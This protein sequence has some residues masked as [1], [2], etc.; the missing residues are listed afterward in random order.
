[1]KKDSSFSLNRFWLNFK[2]TAGINYTSF[3]TIFIL[4]VVIVMLLNVILGSVSS[5]SS[6]YHSKHT[7]LANLYFI[8]LYIIGIKFASS[9]FSEMKN[10]DEKITYLMLPA[11]VFEKY[12]CRLFMTTV[13]FFI[14]Y[15][16]AY[17]L[18]CFIGSIINYYLF[19]YPVYYLN[20]YIIGF[21]KIIAFFIVCHSIFFL[22]GIWFN[23]FA[24]IKTIA[25]VCLILVLAI[26]VILGLALML[27]FNE[28]IGP[29]NIDFY[30]MSKSILFIKNWFICLLYIF[31]PVMCWITGYY[32]LKESSIK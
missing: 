6:V 26:I 14:K 25:F 30:H 4:T 16:V 13:I 7:V 29:N 19:G 15:T 2:Y 11:S 18:G 23:K 31:L 1:M 27:K 9:A 8:F 28:L 10:K 5:I 21:W 17:L 12:F 32:K 24:L 20:I 22:G 3:L